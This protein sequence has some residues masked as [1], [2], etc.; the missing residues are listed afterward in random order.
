MDEDEGPPNSVQVENN[1][2]FMIFLYASQLQVTI[3]FQVYVRK[4]RN[5]VAGRI[6]EA[7]LQYDRYVY[8]SMLGQ[9]LV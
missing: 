7:R 1:A 4:V 9:E 6:G 2:L 5:K 3:C 8:R